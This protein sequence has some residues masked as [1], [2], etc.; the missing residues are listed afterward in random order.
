MGMSK[1]SGNDMLMLMIMFEPYFYGCTINRK[2][3]KLLA[4]LIAKKKKKSQLNYTVKCLF[5][6]SEMF[7]VFESAVAYGISKLFG[8]YIRYPDTQWQSL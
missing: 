6:G 5:I 3:S 2:R 4:L 7:N 1:V 8:I